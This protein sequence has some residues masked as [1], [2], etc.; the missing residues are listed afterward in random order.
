MFIIYR[1]E[2][3]NVKHVT[4]WMVRNRIP[5]I[6]LCLLLVVPSLLGMTATK[7][8]YDLLYYLP[9]DLDTV[10]GQ[11][12]L[13]QDF[14]KGAFS[15]L[16][17]EGMGPREQASLEKAVG[18]IPHVDS[19]IGFASLAGDLF[20]A[21]ILPDEVRERFSRGDCM[22]TAVFF[23][24]G[25]SSEET[26][27]AIE[28][29]RA[30]AGEKCFVSGLSA[31]VTD[32]RDLVESQEAVYVGIAVALCALVLMVTM[33]SFLLPLIFLACIGVSVLW[34]LGSN[35]FLGEIS[36]ITKAVAAV[37]Q[38]GVT[39]DYS[40]F[41]WHSYR[42][43]KELLEDRDDAMVEAIHLTFTSILGSSLTT[44]AGF[45]SICF[46]SFT[47]GR[48]L[49]IVMSKGVILG[50]LGTVVL[51]PCVIRLLDG[52]IEKTSH[53]PLLPDVGGIGR[54]VRKHYRALA[55]LM[56]VLAVP[57]FWG[58]S[59]AGVYYDMSR[60][61]PQDLPSIIANNKLEQTFDMSTTHLL[62]VDADVSQRDV[63]RMT[64]EMRGVDGVKDVLGLDSL[65][66]AGIPESILPGDILSMVRSDRWQLM[67]V[68]SAYVI[69]SDEV[70][71][72][73]DALNAILKRYDP[74][75]LLIGEAPCTKDLIACTDHDFTVVSVISIA[76][77]FIII[78]LVQKSLSLPVLL[79]S[80]IELAI[81][82]NL[83]IPF[84]TR[85]E[86]PFVAPILISTIQLGATVDYAI[87]LTTRYKQN[88]ISGMDRMDAV[89]KAVASAARS[90]LVSGM[91]FFAATYGVGLYSNVD[92]IS[93][94]CRLIARGAL[95]S[96]AV[97]L[98]LLPA[99]LLLLDRL[100]VHTTF[101]M[102]A[103]R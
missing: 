99:A 18:Q 3:N 29:I 85:T 21:E 8:K 78:M 45:V 96:V 1:L 36:Y 59:H 34:N 84:Y 22:L 101:D 47:L 27:A 77:I 7:T 66:G 42:D 38:L 37:L 60:V 64:Q 87:L 83:C 6:L 95:L 5:V 79:V 58:Y 57:A 82:A 17:T 4:K 52:V 48:D 10:R 92:M 12:I 72:Q 2:A 51:L 32:T 63:R 69:S 71:A 91:G 50:L 68:N 30:I 73:I 53:T 90:I 80:V 88:R 41:L 54:F 26:M 44:I 49:G 28:K 11:E 15:L 61:M 74:N 56:V 98:L 100:I 67:L 70:N 97:V 25:S 86:L 24:Q 14:G 89:E 20:P 65:L 16:I 40:I 13:L 33:D 31:V 9:Q 93:S 75:G 23:D 46:M 19:V 94:M 103:A 39:L 81:A 102:K 55:V 76:A 35:V 62:L 43:Q